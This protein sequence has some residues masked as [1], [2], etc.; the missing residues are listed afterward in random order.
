MS[1]H[2]IKIFDADD[3]EVYSSVTGGNTSLAVTFDFSSVQGR[4]PHIPASNFFH[5]ISFDQVHV[6]SKKD[7][8]YQTKE[9]VKVAEL[10]NA[11][12]RDYERV[13]T[14]GNSMGAYGAILISGMI[15]ADI[16][17]A[18]APQYS[19][20]PSIMPE[21]KR[22]REAVNQ[23][24]FIYDHLE[25][26]VSDASRNYVIYDPF[27][28]EDRRHVA[29]FGT[30][31]TF[32]EIRL[33]FCGHFPSSFLHELGL[34]APYMEALIFEG[35][36]GSDL[37]R[38]TKDARRRSYHYYL[39]LALILNA[40]GRRSIAIR[41][42]HTGYA[43]APSRP[44]SLLVYVSLLAFDPLY[45]PFVHMAVRLLQTLEGGFAEYDG[46][47]DELWQKLRSYYLK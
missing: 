44:E 41:A 34:L 10:I 13:V 35:A 21:E 22:W 11:R 36:I 6:V 12:R 7:I 9:L 18:F 17:L 32:T 26:F 47:R 20:D 4:P 38:R 2:W 8:W 43:L 5:G 45:Y 19:V 46:V 28:P 14:Y 23:I 31:Q 33:P 25:T 27:N 16:V 39:N 37:V 29:M 15:E 1:Q 30:V 3:L 24:T 40:K 42:A